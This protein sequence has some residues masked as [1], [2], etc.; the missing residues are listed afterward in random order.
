MEK[1]YILISGASSGIGKACAQIFAKNGFSLILFARR[2]KKL[3]QLQNE[4][5]SLYP[6]IE[7]HSFQVDVRNPK[8]IENAINQFSLGLKNNIHIL[9]N[10]A[11]LALDR[12]TI[13]KG[14]IEDWD[15]MIDTNL[16]GLL[17]LSKKIIPIMIENKKGHIINMGSIAGKEVYPEGNVYCASKAAV[18]SISKAMRIDLLPHGI[19]VSQISPGAVETE[20]SLV[21]YKGNV[22]LA[23]NV[24]NGFIPLKAEDI[25]ESIFFLANQPEHVCINDIIITPTAQANSVFFNKIL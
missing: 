7:V 8:E 22:D 1:K 9:L 14:I 20:F 5:K 24:Y 21:R 6:E 13:D 2:I 17:Y 16:K 23:K 25:A 3:E 11:G 15:Q 4:L 19:K 12:S 10:N 18:D